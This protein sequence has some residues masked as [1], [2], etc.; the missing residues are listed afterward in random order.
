MRLTADKLAFRL[1]EAGRQADR[2]TLAIRY[3]DGKA[4]RKTVAIRPRTGAFLVLADHSRE[5]FRALYQRR[6]ALRAIALS[7]PAPK[8]D[9]GQTD[10][11]ASQDD[12]RQHALGDALAK[13]RGRSGFAIIL[14]GA[15]VEVAGGSD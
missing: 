9:T 10:L 12:R 6:V 8:Q 7:V 13:I 2:L 4:A 14:S 5:L 1:R 15:N 3:A 11:F